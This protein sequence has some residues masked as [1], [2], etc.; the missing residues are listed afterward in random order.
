MVVA[1]CGALPASDQAGGA[2]VDN[3]VRCLKSGLGG[4]AKF[5]LARTGGPWGP[6]ETFLHTNAKETKACLLALQAFLK[7]AHGVHVNCQLDNMTAVAYIN[8][9]GP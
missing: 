9:M 2:R 3:A 1:K 7:D 8:H 6:Q 5:G 4:G